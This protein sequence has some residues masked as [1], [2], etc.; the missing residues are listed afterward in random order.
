MLV[1]ID[2]LGILVGGCDCDPYCCEVSKICISPMFTELKSKIACLIVDNA[3]PS[4][5]HLATQ[6][7]FAPIPIEMINFLHKNNRFESNK[8]IPLIDSIPVLFLSSG[9]D[10]L[11]RRPHMKQLYTLCN[12]PQK[13]M[14]KFPGEGHSSSHNLP[15]YWETLEDFVS[16]SVERL[17]EISA[18]IMGEDDFMDSEM[19]KLSITAMRASDVESIIT[20]GHFV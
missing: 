17:G 7:P 9:N 5:N 8:R 6:Y 2:C 12:S 18:G 20:S 16:M 14:V 10:W 11:I 4:A 19:G 13:M 15:K 3:W 1:S